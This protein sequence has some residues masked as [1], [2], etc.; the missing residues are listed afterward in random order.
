MSEVNRAA[1]AES[2]ASFITRFGF[3]YLDTLLK[4]AGTRY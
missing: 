2:D 3:R 4:S 1:P